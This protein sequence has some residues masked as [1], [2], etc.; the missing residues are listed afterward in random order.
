MKKIYALILGALSL[1]SLAHAQFTV[2]GVVKD[3]Q[4]NQPIPGAAVI[5]PHT[6]T[7]CTT[8]AQGVFTLES[9]TDFD[10][11]SL[12][13][14]GYIRKSI[15]LKNKNA[16]L[17]VTLES[18]NTSLNE[19]QVVGLASNRKLISTPGSVDLMTLKD[20]QRND[21]I[22]LQN[23]IN[24]LA[25]VKMEMRSQDQGARM[26]IRGYGNSTNFNGMGYKAYL[27]GIPLTD[28][29]GTTIMDDV[30]FSS[31]GSVEVVKGPSSSLYGSGI[32]GVV[33][34]TSQKAPFG[35]SIRQDFT[36]GSYGLSRTNTAI[37]VGTD[38]VNLFV[39]YGHQEY[40][41]YR[42]HEHSD[43]DYLTLNGDIYAGE[44]RTVSVFTSYSNSYA[45]LPGELDSANFRNHPTMADPAYL[46]NNA[47]VRMESTRMGVSQTYRFN[48][49]PS[50]QTSVFTSST[51][52]EQ[53]TAVG[54]S[55]TN[56]TKFGA[57][58][59]FVF[60]PSIGKM[61]TKWILG[62]EFLKNNIFAKSYGLTNTILGPIKSDLQIRPMVYSAFAQAELNITPS[63]L[64]TA[65]AS[66]NVAEYGISDYVAASATH[67]STSGD[68]TFTPFVTPRI[69]LN[70]I[71]SDKV[72]LYASM[73]EGYSA[74][75]TNQVV[76]SQTGVVNKDLKPEIGT[77]YEIGTKGNLLSKRLNYELA[78]FSMD[79]TNKL[80]SENFA[81]SGTTPAYTAT[82]NAGD[83]KYQGAELT[84]S[85]NY[86]KD[87]SAA[88]TLVRPF[89]SYTYSNF[90]NV[91][92]KSDNN[93]NAQ[94]IDYSN[95]KVSGIAPNMF[96][97]GIDLETHLG[98]YFNTTYQ[99]VDRMPLDF[100]N[101]HYADAYGLWNAKL[102]FRTALGKKVS[103][104]VFGG[105]NNILSANYSS[106]LFLNWN[107]A[108]DPA[109]FLPM[110]KINY[111]AGVS[112]KFMLK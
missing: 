29:D 58:T 48:S 67:V 26:V 41:G 71:I 92:F 61:K 105:V 39:N 36:A 60:T 10:S 43:K 103:L 108:T 18:S 11:I 46:A 38:K 109:S 64:L 7:G 93:D 110:A 107:P 84:V 51:A 66:L 62:G 40:G 102:G 35:T 97:A 6:T 76:I 74:P 96:N 79:V 86:V 104:N 54:L 24:L 94:T 5:V 9:K 101:K 98:I 111:Y 25:G 59:Q 68:K 89:I 69:A 52:I 4:N 2:K 12:N 21:G 34:M 82:V 83:V 23:T 27:N 19:V 28:A 50:N 49:L 99:Y 47:Y 80:V 81:A 65:G 100:I 33:N 63:T 8:D 3:I 15:P 112:I 30:D 20:L 16:F 55:E 31:L 87:S 77:S 72:S 85:Y 106:L 73:S 95:K 53:P 32:A 22:F 1:S 42:V 13:A 37:G 17:T 57:R 75:G 56:K 78:L 45:L 70:Q 91:S 14:L 44:K 88:I 90:Y